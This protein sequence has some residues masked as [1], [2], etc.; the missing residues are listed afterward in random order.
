MFHACT[1]HH[2]TWIGG[3][4]LPGECGGAGGLCGPAGLDAERFAGVQHHLRPA[5]PGRVIGQPVQVNV[6]GRVAYVAQQAWMQNASLEYNITFGQPFQVEY[7]QPFQ[8]KYRP[9]FQCTLSTYTVDQRRVL[10]ILSW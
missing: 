5:L 2:Y 10:K 3:P 8:V 9:A 4:S 6:V 7:W 1:K